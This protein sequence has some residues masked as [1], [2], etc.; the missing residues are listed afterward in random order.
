VV[1]VARAIADLDAAEEV[2]ISHIAEALQY[3]TLDRRTATLET[4]SG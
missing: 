4:A 3:R 2:R 1:R